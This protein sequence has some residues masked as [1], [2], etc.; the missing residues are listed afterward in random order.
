MCRACQLSEVA[1]FIETLLQSVGCSTLL[2][3]RVTFEVDSVRVNA[4]KLPEME[5]LGPQ[6]VLATWKLSWLGSATAPGRLTSVGLATSA[7]PNAARLAGATE[8]HPLLRNRG[9][10][11]GRQILALT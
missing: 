2:A 9:L 1:G 4:L 11:L 3:I 7:L 6:G 8:D 10:D 5:E